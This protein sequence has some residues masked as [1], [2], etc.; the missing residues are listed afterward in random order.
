M[1]VKLWEILV[2]TAYKG[3]GPIRRKHHKKW[4]RAVSKIAG[5]LTLFKPKKGCWLSDSKLFKEKM[6]PVRIA[7]TRNEIEKIAKFTSKH[8]HQKAVMFYLVSEVVVIL[9]Y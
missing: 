5:G 7:A 9:E 2:P 1:T 4:D 3:V 8:Y 6:I